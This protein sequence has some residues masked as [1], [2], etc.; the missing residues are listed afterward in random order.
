MWT[1]QNVDIFYRG[2]PLLNVKFSLNGSEIEIVKEFIYLLNR[3]C[4]FNKAI[5]KH[6]EKAKKARYK[7][8]KE[9]AL[10]DYIFYLIKCLKFIP[11]IRCAH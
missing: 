1:K 9:D 3:T 6:A 2:R 11:E 8:I 10:I 5:T 7:V 4:N